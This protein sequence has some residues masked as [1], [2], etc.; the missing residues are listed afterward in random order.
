MPLANQ[1]A[2]IDAP[3]DKVWA[4]MRE[5]IERPDKYVPGV[6]E[7]EIVNRFDDGAV[8]RVML[9]RGEAG[10]KRIHEI[11]SASD[12][13]RTVVFLLKDD[14]AFFRLHHQHRV[15]DRRRHRPRL[16]R[17][18]DA[19]IRGRREGRARHCRHDPWRRVARQGTGRSRLRGPARALAVG[20]G[21]TFSS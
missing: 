17:Q 8:E 2:L 14:P 15:R 4:M 3:A 1:Q 13:T 19:K 7:V 10:D 6:V 21:L 12:A 11:I 18:L 9:A 16:H 5:K 20:Q